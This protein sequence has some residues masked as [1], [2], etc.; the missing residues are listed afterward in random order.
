MLEL[1]MLIVL[2]ALISVAIVRTLGQTIQGKYDLIN[3]EIASW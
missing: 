1:L 3:T 2:I